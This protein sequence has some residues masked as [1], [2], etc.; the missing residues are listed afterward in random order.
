[1]NFWERNIFFLILLSR[2]KTLCLDTKDLYMNLVCT[3]IQYSK[4]KTKQ[5]NSASSAHLVKFYYSMYY[6]NFLV[7]WYKTIYL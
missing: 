5:V 3:T 6:I 1:M 4:N 7:S 2:W